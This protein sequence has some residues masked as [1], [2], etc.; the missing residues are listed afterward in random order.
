MI[1][2]TF[3]GYNKLM[4]EINCLPSSSFPFQWK[5]GIK[6]EDFSSI[7]QESWHYK[8]DFLVDNGSVLIYRKSPTSSIHEQAE[9]A[10]DVSIVRFNTLLSQ[11][12]SYPVDSTGQS[13]VIV[14]NCY[15]TVDG[16]WMVSRRLCNI[17]SVILEHSYSSDL[18]ITHIKVLNILENINIK[19]GIL[20][21]TER[22]DDNSFAL[23]AYTIRKDENDNIFI[24][25]V[26]SFGNATPSANTINFINSLNPN[27][28][29]GIGLSNNLDGCT[30]PNLQMYELIINHQDLLS[31]WIGNGN[32]NQNIIID[33]CKIDLYKVRTKIMNMRNMSF[34]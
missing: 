34:C 30:L 6:K 32:I 25:N 13:S 5:T 14:N 2:F 1:P 33:D 17:P 21:D 7:V 11:D 15:Y 16:S 4:E 29:V 31:G 28:L 24:P 20:F 10:I 8:G 27:N 23:I 3:E 9:K 19:C 26:F 12:D 18:R 22:M